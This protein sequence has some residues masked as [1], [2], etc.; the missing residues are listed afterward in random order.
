VNLDTK[1][2]E[3]T[4]TLRGRGRPR[5]EGGRDTRSEILRASL[6]LFAA[7][8]YPDT[9]IREIAR[10]VGITEA[11]IYGHFESKEKILLGLFETYGPGRI[12]RL[13]GGVDKVELA[14]CPV[15]VVTDLLLSFYDHF[16]TEES[17]KLFKVHAMEAIRSG[18]KQSPAI[19]DVECRVEETLDEVFAFLQEKGVLEQCNRR[20]LIAQLL[21]PVMVMRFHLFKSGNHSLEAVANTRELV[22]EHVAIFFKRQPAPRE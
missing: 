6:D 1:D 4:P 17:M 5:K 8:T 22:K 13:F 14:A 3:V 16:G 19:V 12:A 20:V 15:R 9:S 7:K 21:A 11:A 10:T 2:V 18:G